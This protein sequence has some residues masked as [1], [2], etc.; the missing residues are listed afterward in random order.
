M[1]KPTLLVVRRVGLFLLNL[2]GTTATATYRQGRRAAAYLTEWVRLSRQTRAASRARRALGGK[3]CEQGQG[4]EDLRRQ[5]AALDEPS[6]GSSTNT[7]RSRAQDRQREDL[8][9]RLADG[10]LLLAEPPPGVGAVYRDFRRALGE[11]GKS[12]RRCDAARTVL[13]PGDWATGMRVGLGAATTIALFVGT[14]VLLRSS[15]GEPDSVPDG[16]ADKILA[17]AVSKPT[18]HKKAAPVPVTKPKDSPKSAPVPEDR[19]DPTPTR[20]MTLARAMDL[21]KDP[22]KDFQVDGPVEWKPGRLTLGPAGSVRR[23]LDLGS[24]AKLTLRLAFTPLKDGQT[25]TTRFAFQIRD[26][27]DFVVEIV[28]RREKGKTVGELRLIDRDTPYVTNPR[29]TKNNPGS[30]KTTR[31]LRTFEWDDDFPDG[32]WTFRHH[33][34]LLT[35]YRG[36]KQMGVAYADK[37]PKHPLTRIEAGQTHKFPLA[38]LMLWGNCA[39]GE[40][41]E[42]AGWSLQQEGAQVTCLEVSGSASPSYRKTMKNFDD[43]LARARAARGND[44]PGYRACI[45]GRNLHLRIALP[46]RDYQE[47]ITVG[48]SGRKEM[49]MEGPLLNIPRWLGARHPYVALALEGLG[50]QMYWGGNFADAEQML[51]RALAISA[52]S[53]GPLHPDH[54]S[55]LSSLGRVYR[56]MGR[57]DRAEPLLTQA[58][59][60]ALEVFGARS[61]RYAMATRDLAV[62]YEDSGRIA[63]AETILR[64]AAELDKDAP[65]LDRAEA[66]PTLILLAE[67]EARM[68]E[69][70]KAEGL[71]IQA[72]QAIGDLGKES[73]SPRPPETWRQ[74]EDRV[75]ITQRLLVDLGKGQTGLAWKRFHDGQRD[76]AR[77]LARSAFLMLVEFYKVYDNRHYDTRFEGWNSQMT[78]VQVPQGHDLHPE[79]GRVMVTLAEL[80]A[81]LGDEV[82]S[83][84]C[85]EVTDRLYGLVERDLAVLCR[86]M[87]KLSEVYPSVSTALYNPMLERKRLEWVCQHQAR[88][89]NPLAPDL[90]W[91]QLALKKFETFAGREHPDTVDMLRILARRQWRTSG[92][93]KAEPILRDACNRAVDLSHRVVAGLPEAQAYLFLE[94]NRPPA[95]LMLSCYRATNKDHARDAYEVIWRSKALATRLLMERRRLLQAVSGRPE[96]TR[97]AGE[98]QSTRQ[99]LAQLSLAAPVTAAAQPRDQQLADLTGRKENLERELARLSEPFRRTRDAGLAG[100]ADM[101]RRLPAN[102][103]VVDFVERW[104]WTPPGPNKSGPRSSA[105]PRRHPWN[106]P[107]RPWPMQDGGLVA[108]ATKRPLAGPPIKRRRPQPR[109]RPA[110]PK[111]DPPSPAAPAPPP[112]DTLPA[113]SIWN[114][115]KLT[116]DGAPA[117]LEITAREGASFKGKF[118]FDQINVNEVAGTFSAGKIEWH[119]TKVLQGK[120]NQPTTGT[121]KGNTIDAKFRMVFRRGGKNYATTGSIRLT[122]VRKAKAL[123]AWGQ[124]RSYDAFVLRAAEGEPGWSAAWVELGDADALDRLLDDYVAGLRSRGKGHREIG[125]QLRARL[126]KPVEAALADCRMA[127]LIP[128]GRLAQVPW[129]ALPGRRAGSYLLEDY[130][131]AQAPYGQHVARLLMEPA[132]QGDGFLLVGGIDYGPAGKWGY[133]KGTAAEVAELYKLKPGP[134]TLRLAGASATKSRLRE[135]LPGR[136][137]VHMATHGA[138]LDS[139]PQRDNRP[140]PGRD[141]SSA[142]ALFDVTARNPLL[143]SMLVLAGANRPAPTDAQGLPVGS[144]SFLTAEEVM[145]L[146]LT[147]TE[148]MV[149]SACQTGAGKVKGGE[150]VFSLQ[151]AFQVAGARSVV[152]TLWSVDDEATRKLMAR[153]Y[154]NLW[155]KKMTKLE[156][157]RQ[158]QLWLLREGVKTGLVR[159]LDVID[160]DQPM[161]TDGRVPPFYW[162]AFQLSGDWR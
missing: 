111:K 155:G 156:A 92:A 114:G 87:G 5:I 125:E 102:T 14:L 73:E 38:Y 91:R 57:L 110:P 150:G 152:A 122:S 20:G 101:V 95:D 113:G 78:N 70:E 65:L 23:A 34:G 11:L 96:L 3:L 19:P 48:G 69:R 26:R 140:A 162:A 82:P 62:L 85:I 7:S 10:T 33:H 30:V 136:R 100:V 120:A 31:T 86:I 138:F 139:G 25:S 94:A 61:G 124:T 143:L 132:P 105:L 63:E 119:A 157:L 83:L 99:E 77:V 27:G 18:D 76:E 103:A 121:L 42:V 9:R 153:F 6:S 127:I 59:Q 89:A 35:V 24:Q 49:E 4:D 52:E 58:R 129:A 15:R 72:K 43:L 67:I 40:P 56:E 8:L 71:I 98:L 123:E 54:A 75:R 21:Q 60:T 108:V 148:M 147:R 41:L 126:W 107:S 144:D 28:R 64:K 22:R 116:S 158:A 134:K 149:L 55:K 151:R 81:A 160:D 112:P 133:L 39:I 137:Y 84:R 51:K 50:L 104:Q 53:L 90:Y 145:G 1:R 36:N 32:P 79:Y 68:G 13:W 47:K 109:P 29:L 130:A 115:E 118:T 135:L 93:E 74:F 159:G 88:G 146:D 45:Q 142:G 44:H 117:E 2:V 106:Q 17:A 66:L 141:S 16:Q 12:R 131:L 154:E 128:D 46:M 161:K 80:F 37:E 97:L